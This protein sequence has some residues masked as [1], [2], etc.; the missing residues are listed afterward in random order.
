M[1]KVSGEVVSVKIILSEQDA[2]AG[3]LAD[4]ELIFEG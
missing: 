1:S 3:K 2:P 4:A